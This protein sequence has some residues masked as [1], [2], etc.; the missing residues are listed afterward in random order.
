MESFSPVSSKRSSKGESL[1]SIIKTCNACIISKGPNFPKAFKKVFTDSKSSGLQD[2]TTWNHGNSGTI[3]SCSNV[4]YNFPVRRK[5]LAHDPSH[6]ITEVIE[7]VKQRSFTSLHTSFCVVVNDQIVANTKISLV[8]AN[9]NPGQALLER[10]EHFH[11]KRRNAVILSGNVFDQVTISGFSAPSHSRCIQYAFVNNMALEVEKLV[12]AE[13]F[14]L[15]F[16]LISESA[17]SLDISLIYQSLRNALFYCKVGPI[18]EKALSEKLIDMENEEKEFKPTKLGLFD[19]LYGCANKQ[20]IPNN[21]PKKAIREL[22]EQAKNVNRGNVVGSN[23]SCK[24]NLRLAKL[25]YTKN[26]DSAFRFNKEHLSR[27]K[28]IKQ[29]ENKFITAQLQVGDSTLIVAIDQHAADERVRLEN[30]EKVMLDPIQKR[31]GPNIC[32]VQYSQIIFIDPDKVQGLI[33]NFQRKLETWFWK[34]EIS[35]LPIQSNKVPLSIKTAPCIFIEN[36]AITLNHEVMMEFLSELEH[37]SSSWCPKRVRE[38][39][40]SKACRGAVM[41]GDPLSNEECSLLIHKLSQ[42][43]LPFQCAHGRP[44]K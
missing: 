5:A 37:D 1:H 14:C 3:V 4:F 38:I 22:I 18:S 9:S 36:E 44:S 2:Y 23:T 41:F 19:K 29:I 30:F 27:M 11:G 17:A 43:T 21:N 6:T 25:K 40:N 26:E 42:C 34:V 31:P 32:S 15:D 7:S 35:T 33:S 12:K 28:V 20:A 39:M 10:F 13:E 24:E 16:V 8:S